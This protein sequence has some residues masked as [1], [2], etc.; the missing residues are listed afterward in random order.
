MRKI[1][2]LI[3]TLLASYP[4]ILLLL[5]T[6]AA[7][8]Y[9]GTGYRPIEARYEALLAERVKLKQ[10]RQRL[11]EELEGMRQGDLQKRLQIFSKEFIVEDEIDE[12]RLLGIPSTAFAASGW[13]LG[14]VA[15]K[16]REMPEEALGLGSLVALYEGRSQGLTLSDGSSFLPTNSLLQACTYLWRKSPTKDFSRIYIE[17]DSTGYRTELEIVYLMRRATESEGAE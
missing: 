8:T 5:L 12:D 2:Y 13:S 15:I 17:R 6:T 10:D 4:V 7:V 9:L 14:S 11:A 1:L 16:E 3:Y